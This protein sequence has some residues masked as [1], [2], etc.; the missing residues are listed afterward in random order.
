MQKRTEIL[1]FFFPLL[2]SSFRRN[3][4]GYTTQHNRL[5]NLLND[6][7]IFLHKSHVRTE[8]I[9]LEISFKFF[10]RILQESRGDKGASRNL[11][12]KPF[13]ADCSVSS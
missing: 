8:F 4:N 3:R 10:P 9:K 2:V 11:S 13:Y 5:S 7:S 12:A 6:P 1:N